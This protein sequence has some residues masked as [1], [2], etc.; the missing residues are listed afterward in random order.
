[1]ALLL[2]LAPASLLAQGGSDLPV[3]PPDAATLSVQQKVESLY[4]QGEY[5][6]AHFIYRKELAP[7]GDKYAQYMVGFMYLTGTGVAE[8]PVLASA[9]YRL[10]AERSFPEF[11]MVRDELLDDLD[12]SQLRESDREYLRLRREYSDL[13]L[14][15][16]SIEKILGENAVTTGSRLQGGSRSVTIVDPRTG[17]NSASDLNNLRAQIRVEK[18][19][20]LLDK[21]LGGDVIETDPGRVNL[22][23]LE[24]I[25]K[26]RVNIIDDR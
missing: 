2:G 25:V 18:Q 4:E 7:I 15:Q 19:L 3:V 22:R 16:E 17:N 20:Q 8:D 1:M 9:W 11:I 21:L 23:E 10:A 24:R 5:E 12:E 14:L 26:D 6:R 13:V